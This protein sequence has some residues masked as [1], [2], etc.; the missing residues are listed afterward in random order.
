MRAKQANAIPYFEFN[1]MPADGVGQ[2]AVFTRRGGV[3]AAPFDSL[4]L[5]VAVADD[6][7]RVDENR[8]RAYGTLERTNQS[9]V[10]AHLLHNA[11]VLRVATAQHGQIGGRYDGLI[12][13]EPGCGLTMNFADCSPILIYDLRKRAIGLG[14]AG[15]QGAVKDLPGALVRAMQREFGSKP[16]ELWAGVG[17]SIGPCC[18]EVGEPVVSA[19]RA[20]YDEPEELFMDN[21]GVRPYFDLPAANEL[22]LR[23]AGVEHVEMAGLCTACHT[24]LFFSHRAEG[25]RTGRFG[26]LFL[27]S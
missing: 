10:H 3:S 22:R 9:V 18:Y 7:A 20:A 17:P 8:R 6:P 25:G 26:V 5:S 27:L 14:H 13:D 12:T 1:T 21:G 11:D 4:N 16:A 2:H 23:Q 24:D 19:V 15:W